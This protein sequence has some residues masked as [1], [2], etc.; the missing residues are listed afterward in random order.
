MDDSLDLFAYGMYHVVT[1]PM[2][3]VEDVLC[4]PNKS[5]ASCQPTHFML[6]KI[7]LNLQ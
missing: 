5:L 2:D 6:Q 3:V 1:V 4:R 7:E